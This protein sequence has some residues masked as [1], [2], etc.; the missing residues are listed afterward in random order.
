M[1]RLSRSVVASKR[2]EAVALDVVTAD[3]PTLH[4]AS[5]ELAL[6][7]SVRAIADLIPSQ[8]AGESLVHM[9][10]SLP[11]HS[12]SV[13]NRARNSGRSTYPAKLRI[14]RRIAP[15]SLKSVAI[16]LPPAIGST[17]YAVVIR[18]VSRC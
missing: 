2:L 4:A 12:T 15:A 11:N 18:S 10:S 5:D 3:L 17:V 13:F 14:C 6:R 9:G 7:T 8:E 1:N 16:D